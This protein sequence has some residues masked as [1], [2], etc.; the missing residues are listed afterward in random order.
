MRTIATA[1]ALTLVTAMSAYAVPEALTE[2]QVEG[3][4]QAIRGMQGGCTVEDTNIQIDGG[5]YE[6]DNVIC[7]DGTYN[8]FLDGNF[9]VTD[10]V[11][12]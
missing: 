5:G 3:V 4:Q 11:K 12:G 1:L 2:E 10:K 8:V 7:E 9:A 6:A